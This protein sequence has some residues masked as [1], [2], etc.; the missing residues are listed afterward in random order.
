MDTL[1]HYLWAVVLYWYFQAP[2]KWLVGLTGAL[3]D[4]FSFGILFGM[5]MLGI[6]SFGQGP[7]PIEQ[8]PGFIFTLYNITHSFIPIG[9]VAIILYFSARKWWYLSWGWILGIAMDIPTHTRDY[10]P[11]PFLWPLSRYAFDGFSWGQ[12][13]FLI[14]NYSLLILAFAY[15]FWRDFAWPQ[16]NS[17]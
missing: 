3:P 4:I 8:I 10:F 12:Q 2:K 14:L 6:V 15:L 9:I 17:K 13:W 11:T 1:S 16:R 5:N 7:P